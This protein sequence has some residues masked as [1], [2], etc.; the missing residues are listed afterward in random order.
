[1]TSLNNNQNFSLSVDNLTIIYKNGHLALEDISFSLSSSTICA[2]L[3]INGGG[4]STLFKAIMGIIKPTQGNIIL[5]NGSIKKAL[6]QNLIAYVP[7]SEEIDWNFP[8]LVKDVVM[9]GRYG[10]MGILRIP[11]NTDKTIV[12][13]SLKRVGMLE[14][15]NRQIGELSGGQRK[16]VFIAR[17][18]AQEAKVMLLDEP[19]TGIDITTEHAIIDLLKEFRAQ[20]N[21]ILISTHNIS[22]IATFC[23]QVLLIN[24]RLLASG[25]IKTEFTKENLQKAFGQR[26]TME[27]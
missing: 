12:A 27:I 1:M 19:F 16:R 15:E 22:S 13:E 3:G 26:F 23:D 2:L 6:K 14:Y 9:M 25:N 5:N 7:Q 4:K 11:K 17:A 24:K 18:L 8:I 10:K 21:L 20:G